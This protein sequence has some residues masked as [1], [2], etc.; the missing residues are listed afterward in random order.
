M[1]FVLRSLIAVLVTSTLAA[2]GMVLRGAES[3]TVSLWFSPEEL[4]TGKTIDPTHPFEFTLHLEGEPDTEYV[5]T[6]ESSAGAASCETAPSTLTTNPEGKA[7]YECLLGT[8]WSAA[9]GS[10]TFIASEGDAEVGRITAQFVLAT[11]VVE[12]TPLADETPDADVEEKADNH[13][14]CVSYWA[15][16]AKD[17]GLEG[18][19]KGAFVSMVAQSDCT[20]VD[21]E[22]FA[23]ELEAALAAQEAEQEDAA[24]Q[25]DGSKGKKKH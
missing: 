9:T 18:S 8:T 16:R 14:Q 7:V 12:P 20:G 25:E 22:E 15:H 1:R 6:T 5:L 13:G 11:P 2:G 4:V 19:R 24:T 21:E 3:D 23:D 10:I 17:E